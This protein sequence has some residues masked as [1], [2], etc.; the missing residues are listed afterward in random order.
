MWTYAQK[1][2]GIKTYRR[3]N[4][5]LKTRWRRAGIERFAVK[6]NQVEPRREFK[7]FFIQLSIRKTYILLNGKLLGCSQ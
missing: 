5:T 1:P 6:C 7:V 4:L 3:K 2:S